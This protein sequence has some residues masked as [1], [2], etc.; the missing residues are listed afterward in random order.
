MRK[1]IAFWKLIGELMIYFYGYLSV[2][3][4]SPINDVRG[5]TRES[6]IAIAANIETR[7]WRRKFLQSLGLPPEHPRSST[8][9][10]V[11]CFFSIL[12]DTVG[13]HFTLKEVNY[14]CMW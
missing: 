7:Q 10:D 9:D 5:L 12:R 6:L 3:H 8:T 1:I 14:N 4:T 2:M 13:K 11:E